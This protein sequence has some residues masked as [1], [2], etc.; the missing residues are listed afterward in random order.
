MAVDF[1]NVN[2]S[3]IRHYTTDGKAVHVDAGEDFTCIA[4]VFYQ[5]G[6]SGDH[7]YYLSVGGI[8]TAGSMAMYRS[9]GSV[10][11]KPT[12]WL[13]TGV[14]FNT[15][16]NFIDDNNVLDILLRRNGIL[17][18]AHI[19]LGTNSLSVATQSNSQ[20]INASGSLF[21]GARSDLNNT[22][23]WHGRISDVVFSRGYGASTDELIALANGKPLE[24]IP[25]LWRRRQFHAHLKTAKVPQ[26]VDLTGNFV[27]TRQNSG[28]GENEAD[29][30]LFVRN[31]TKIKIPPLLASFAAPQGGGTSFTITPS[32]GT[33]FSGSNE[34]TPQKFFNIAPLGGVVF[35][36]TNTL[37]FT[38]GGVADFTITPS[39]GIVFT[40]LNTITGQNF[41][42]ITPEGQITFNGSNELTTQSFFTISPSGGIVFSGNNQIITVTDFI[43]IPSGGIIFNGNNIIISQKFVTIIPNGGIIFNGNNELIS[44]NSFIIISSGNII[45]SGTN[46]LFS[47]IPGAMTDLLI[48]NNDDVIE[49]GRQF[50][51]GNTYNDILHTYLNLFF[52]FPAKQKPLT[53]LFNRYIKEEGLFLKTLP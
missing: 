40:G 8:S 33:R 48:R 10:P 35:T 29:P 30:K 42:I 43:I 31:S 2:S 38:A 44:Q 3:P 47:S 17:I 28:Y 24:D 21:L 19:G 51:F 15:P 23:E 46:K 53:G 11:D 9:G 26:L 27:L 16:A 52:G 39:G 7:W 1:T 50:G 45:F 6:G 18:R 14:V 20:V 12:S 5:S 32:G 41:F 25:N 13:G 49:F 4:N 36:G 37:T 34:L 22:R